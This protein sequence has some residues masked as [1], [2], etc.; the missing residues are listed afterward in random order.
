MTSFVDIIKPAHSKPIAFAY[1]ACCIF[2]GSLFLALLSQL[3]IP[4][5]F[6]PVPLTLQTFAVLLMGALLGSKRGALAVSLYLAEGACGLP[7]F[8]GG[9]S[10]ISGVTAGYLIGFVLCAFLVGFLLERGWKKS[11]PLTLCALAIGSSVILACGIIW[12][13]LY[14]GV[15]NALAVG[16]YPFLIGDV[17]K[18]LAATALIPSGWKL[19]SK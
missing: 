19:L 10:G 14:V 5:W 15:M 11:Y 6:S 17:M 9:T 18:L 8:A 2:V 1:D 4:L 12:L 3:A 16:L 7:F 13:S